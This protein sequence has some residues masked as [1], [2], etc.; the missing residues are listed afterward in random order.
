[1]KILQL[2]DFQVKCFR[3]KKSKKVE[4]FK[5]DQEILGLKGYGFRV[6]ELEILFSITLLTL[7]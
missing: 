5:G 2:L 4:G 6:K 7:S 1:M 3:R